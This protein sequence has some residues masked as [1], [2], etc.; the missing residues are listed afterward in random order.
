MKR[1]LLAIAQWP[2]SGHQNVPAGVSFFL[3]LVNLESSGLPK[4]LGFIDFNHLLN[5]LW[6]NTLD[7]TPF[8]P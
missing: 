5:H 4:S 7:L 3:S 8:F 6:Q 2:S 1:E